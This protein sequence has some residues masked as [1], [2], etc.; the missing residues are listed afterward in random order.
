MR[1][2]ET[3]GYLIQPVHAGI[4]EEYPVTRVFVTLSKEGNLAGYRPLNSSELALH[5]VVTGPT[6]A[7][8][9]PADMH[10][11]S[12]SQPACDLRLQLQFAETPS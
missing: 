7:K 2:V 1:L 10:R 5:P 11:I 3:L 12:R 9:H 4:V 8:S 6:A